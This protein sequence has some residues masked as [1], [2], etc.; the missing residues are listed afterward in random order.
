MH[1]VPG[2]Q[3]M[4]C[5]DTESRPLRFDACHQFFSIAELLDLFLEECSVQVLLNCTMVC[6]RWRRTIK[7]SKLLREHMFLRPVDKTEGVEYRLNPLISTYFAPVLGLAS[8]NEDTLSEEAVARFEE[9]NLCTAEDLQ[10]MAWA[11][12]TSLHAP[13][14]RAFAHP[15]ASWRK[16][17][18]SQPP[19]CRLDWWHNWVHDR[20][21]VGSVGS[22]LASR[23]SSRD[24]EAANGWGHQDLNGQHVTLGMLWDLVES[25][26]TRG[27]FTR[28]QFFPRGKLV[29]DD[30]H[31]TFRERNHGGRWITG[32]RL[33]KEPGWLEPRVKITTQ[34]VWK[35]IPWKCAGF[36]MQAQQWV[37][38]RNKRPEYY[39]G[40]GFNT[41]WADCTYDG[42]SLP[43][44]SMSEGFRWTGLNGESSGL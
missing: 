43:R 36:H 7:Y 28:V 26:L 1:P 34:Q 25:R 19:I 38:M 33:P 20:S 9:G 17:L 32:H 16:M 13:T 24:G 14:R 2:I 15:K 23:V 12:G 10:S 30:E 3:A 40:D 4:S 22:W 18:V 37:T 31:A 21:V 6:R 8:A 42:P 44:W 27:C 41:L 29:S 5:V 39:E 11:R 35:R